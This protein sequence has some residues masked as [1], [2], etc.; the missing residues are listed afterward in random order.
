MRPLNEIAFSRP[1]DI[2]VFVLICCKYMSE[3]ADI[4]TEKVD[5]QD[6]K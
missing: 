1:G 2:D 3:K 4:D 5:I 6:Q